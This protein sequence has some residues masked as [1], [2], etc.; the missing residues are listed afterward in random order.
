MILLVH[1]SVCALGQ[2]QDSL[3]KQI[4]SL[5]QENDPAAA[6]TLMKK[7]IAQYHLKQDKDAETIDMMKGSVAMA[8][9]E[10]G[11]LPGV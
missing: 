8:Y 4:K 3:M 5:S 10:K 11:Q 7:I 1:G 2:Q 6:K 9:L